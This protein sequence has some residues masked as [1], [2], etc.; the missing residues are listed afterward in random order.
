MVQHRSV[1]QQDGM[2]V[3]KTQG[4]NSKKVI[5]VKMLSHRKHCH[6]CDVQSH[7]KGQVREWGSGSGTLARQPLGSN[8]VGVAKL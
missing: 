5:V 2:F 4:I 1:R 6:E 8:M 3:C 7:P